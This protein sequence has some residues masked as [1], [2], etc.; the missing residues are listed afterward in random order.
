MEGVLAAPMA[1]S[2]CSSEEA[3]EPTTTNLQH[4]LPNERASRAGTVLLL[5]AAGKVIAQRLRKP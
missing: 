4:R 2:R 5:V 1:Q 3:G